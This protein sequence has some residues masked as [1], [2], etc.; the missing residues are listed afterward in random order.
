MRLTDGTERETGA[1][2]IPSLSHFPMGH[3]RGEIRRRT[4][5]LMC[6]Q[7][8]GGETPQFFKLWDGTK[9]LLI[10]NTGPD[11]EDRTG[12]FVIRS[13]TCSPLD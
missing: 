8:Y 7:R 9:N 12:D 13:L 2:S 4:D 3:D 10:E 11:P 5:G 1:L 6:S